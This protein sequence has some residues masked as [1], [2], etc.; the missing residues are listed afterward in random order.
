M[1]RMLA[2]AIL[3]IAIIRKYRE[4]LREMREALRYLKMIS[5][6]DVR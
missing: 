5:H 3:P 2:V 1:T 4:A 6:R